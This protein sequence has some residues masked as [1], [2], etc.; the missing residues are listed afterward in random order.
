MNNV[1]TNA[2]GID[3]A[4]QTVQNGLYSSLV[5]SW[6][7]SLDGY[8]RVFK[9]INHDQDNYV[10]QWWDS[11][12]LD[13][14]DVNYNDKVSGSFCFIES[15][16]HDTE[17]GEV[18]VSDVKCVFMVNLNKIIPNYTERAD[19]KAKIDVLNIL[20]NNNFGMYSITGT[21]KGVKNV[22]SGFDTS[23]ILNTDMQPKHC[24]SI[25]I[26]LSY[27]LKCS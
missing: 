12:K 27:Y 21:E 9:N 24:F 19:E 25:N 22:F 13:Y 20:Q 1:L 4:I 17:D 6:V 23:K 8:G 15:E 10:P 18:Y 14:R 7:D 26:K 3:D 16:K 2:V 11:D 5:G